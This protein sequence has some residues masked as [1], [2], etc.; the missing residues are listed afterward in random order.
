MK[1][2]GMDSCGQAWNATR[3]TMFGSPHWKHDPHTSHQ[4]GCVRAV[5]DG[6]APHALQPDRTVSEPVVMSRLLSYA[7][8]GAASRQGAGVFHYR[9]VTDFHV[10]AWT[11]LKIVDCPTPYS[12]ASRAISPWRPL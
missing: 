9:D 1:P 6:C 4:T 11:M 5:G 3:P 12:R 7:A 8:A 10:S 2:E